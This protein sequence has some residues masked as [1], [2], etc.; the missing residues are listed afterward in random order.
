MADPFDEDDRPQ[1][2]NHPR[3]RAGPVTAVVERIDERIAAADSGRSSG[4]RR[5]D[6]RK[7]RA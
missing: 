2:E 5:R 4:S 3:D 7:K 6:A 1:D